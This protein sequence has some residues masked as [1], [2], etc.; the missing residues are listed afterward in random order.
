MNQGL[1]PSF[2]STIKRIQ[3]NKPAPAA[4]AV[5]RRPIVFRLCDDFRRNRIHLTTHGQVLNTQLVLN[6]QILHRS[7]KRIIKL[8]RLTIDLLDFQT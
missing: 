6:M 8:V 1:P 4:P 7:S 3:A 5:F 2:A